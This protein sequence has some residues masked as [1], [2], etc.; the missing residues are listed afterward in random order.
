MR[1][2]LQMHSNRG[3]L[4]VLIWD[5]LLRLFAAVVFCGVSRA[6]RVKRLLKF[7]YLLETILESNSNRIIVGTP[8]NAKLMTL[9]K[10]VSSSVKL[11]AIVINALLI[12]Q[13]CPLSTILHLSKE[14]T[15]RLLDPSCL[16]T[17]VPWQS[18][19]ACPSLFVTWQW[20]DCLGYVVVDSTA[21]INWEM[22]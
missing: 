20:I 14:P 8:Y 19:V 9:R 4:G 7:T 5:G 13:H 21:P 1:A 10:C 16:Y 17:T 18:A 2:S 15:T 3:T 22:L 11:H 6:F 12:H